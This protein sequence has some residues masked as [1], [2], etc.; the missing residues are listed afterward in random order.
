MSSLERTKQGDFTIDES[1]TISDIEKGNYKI[2]D[3]GTYFKNNKGIF[4]AKKWNQSSDLSEHVFHLL[5]AKPKAE[6]PMHI[7]HSWSSFLKGVLWL[8]QN[9][10]PCCINME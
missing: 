4:K 7:S 2:I 5:K 3:I 8:N 10:N 6:G 1:Y 9:T